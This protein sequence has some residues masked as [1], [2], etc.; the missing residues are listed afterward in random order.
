MGPLYSNANLFSG[1]FIY[2]FISKIVVSVS[3]A[4][5]RLPLLMSSEKRTVL[6]R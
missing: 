4:V 6:Q 5:T 1:C 2:L 3:S